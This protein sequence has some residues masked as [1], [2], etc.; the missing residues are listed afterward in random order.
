[1]SFKIYLSNDDESIINTVI[2]IYTVNPTASREGLLYYNTQLNTLHVSTGVDTWDSL[3]GGSIGDALVSIDGLTTTGDEII[4]TTASNTYAVS[5]IS[6]VGRTFISTSSASGQRS[7]LGLVIGTNVQAHSSV[8]DSL[9]SSAATADRLVYTSG[10]SYAGTILDSWA[11]ANI[12]T[13]SSAASL[14][15]TLSTLTATSVATTNGLLRVTGANAVTESLVQIDTSQNVT[16]INDITIGNDLIITGDLGGISSTERTQLANIDSS[17]INA[18]QWGYVG[19]LDQSL[20]TTDSPTYVGLTLSSALAMGSS[21]ITGLATPTATTDATTKAYVDAVA[22]GTGLS[23]LEAVDAGTVVTLTGSPTYSSSAGT[24]TAS[25]TTTA[26]SIDGVATSA[27]DGKR[28]LVKNQAILSQNGIYTRSADS[29]GNWVL[30][31]TTDFNTATIAKDTFV[32]VEVG[33]TSIP[34]SSWLL[35]VAVT[36]FDPVVA[37]SDVVWDQFSGAPVLTPNDGITASG[38]NWNIDASARF[39][40]TGVAPN[41]ELELA[42]VGTA[43]GGSG[44]VVTSGD[45]SKIMVTAAANPHSSAVTLVN[46]PT[47]TILGSSD[48]QTITNKTATSNTNNLIARALWN[49]SGSNSVSTYAASD[50]T[51][52]QVLTATGATTATWQTPSAGAGFSPDR[53]VFVYQSAP[54]STPNYSTIAGAIS[55]ASALTPTAANPVIIIIYPGTYTESNPL[56]VPQHVTIAADSAIPNTVIMKGSNA[57][58]NMIVLSGNCRIDALIIDGEVTSS[59]FAT[60]GIV[61]NTAVSANT[62]LIYN[63]TVKNVSGSGIKISG[64]GSQFSKVCIVKNTSCQAL[65]ASMTMACGYE[66]ELGAI[67]TGVDLT[68]SAFLSAS[69]TLSKG[70]YVH[71]DY[72]FMDLSVVQ[73]SS[74]TDCVEI[75]GGVGSATT[76]AGY[77]NLRIVNGRFSYFS[78]YGVHVNNGG[79]LR[80]SD[81][82]IEDFLGAFANQQTLVST[83]PS[84]EPNFI[85]ILW[86]NTRD[87]LINLDL[88]SAGNLPQERGINL[89]ETINDVRSI[90]FGEVVV[91]TNTVPSALAIG[92][93]DSDTNGMVVFTYDSTTGIS[94]DET[95]DAKLNDS[96]TFTALPP[97][98][99]AGDCLYIGGSDWEY[100]GISELITT[101]I[102]VGGTGLI[103]D[104]LVWEYWN[105]TVW[106]TLPLMV[107][108]GEAPYTNHSNETFAIGDG[109]STDT[110]YNYRF[111]D[112]LSLWS[113]STVTTPS[114]TLPAGVADVSRYYIR[115]RVLTAGAVSGAAEITTLPVVNQIKLHTNHTLI[116]KD[117]FVEFFGDA[118]PRKEVHIPN[119]SLL[120]T[121]ITG[122]SPADAFTLEL[123]TS[124]YEISARLV[125]CRFRENELN[126][127]AFSWAPELSIDTSEPIRVKLELFGGPSGNVVFFCNY[128]FI[129]TDDVG[130]G[131]PTAISQTSGDVVTAVS[132]VGNGK[133]EVVLTLDVTTLKSET[134]VIWFKLG[135]NT[136]NGSDTYGSS[137]YL[138]NI[139]LEYISWAFGGH[140]T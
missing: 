78:R 44:L 56:T 97:T 68:A 139:H 34:S 133:F 6:S 98:P 26:L 82:R 131:T 40:F 88:T 128:V 130:D 134:S 94:T 73:G 69:A 31:R 66:C 23:P 65:T 76:Q 24:L 99:A 61:S 25:T 132:S 67:L 126:T 45:T 53:T 140:F 74:C 113:S 71:D 48:T 13:A 77:P 4:Y 117:G 100:P 109:V 107:T 119:A 10:G 59:T 33:G 118:R 18:T 114:I 62:D 70:Y 16:G 30:T 127:Q 3:S 5:D 32:F 86:L 12:L 22:G 80:G 89:S 105:G 27:V 29:G 83:N 121:K 137:V 55:R 75:N 93:G 96:N 8:L 129:D 135:R 41:K 43:Y 106:T 52:G 50:P 11:R 85:G 17:T 110:L 20:T 19:A 138:M 123:S 92:N 116:D 51:S 14:V 42:T 37:G 7:L 81:F 36:Q 49:D 122:E 28:Y 38:T 1:M 95:S 108:L 124:P 79:V 125:N 103:T 21:K 35:E 63:T 9:I 47:G 112:I 58:S 115:A 101:S 46:A 54:D 57:G 2:P 102:V 64:T 39:S 120:D 136:S 87:D 15:S 104:A 91:G 60:N 84:G 111:G 72:S 90:F